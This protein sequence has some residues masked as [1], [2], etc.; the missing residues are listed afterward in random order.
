MTRSSWTFLA[1][2][3]FVLSLSGAAAQA[4]ELRATTVPYAVEVAGIRIGT[5]EITADRAEEAYRVQAEGRYRVLFWS[6]QISV[7]SDGA[8]T[9]ERPAPR[10]YW[11][12]TRS[13]RASALEI[14]FSP[15]E[16]KPTRWERTPPAP[17]EWTE[18]ALP[19]Q[20]THLQGAIDPATAIAASLLKAPQEGAPPLCQDP[21]RV[22]SGFTVFELRYET[23]E[24]I[25]EDRIDCAATYTP[26]SGH[27]EGSRSVE[28]IAKP[29]AIRLSF[30]RLDGDLWAPAAVSMPT[31]VGT[32]R[33]TKR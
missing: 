8:M 16:A 12:E 19:L 30:Q 33:I 17:A 6:G 9:E 1:A 25:G 13:R 23:V 20:E 26:L 11:L 28:R 14:E 15:E 18:N 4:V 7:A 2:S 10:R 31:T 22:F 32:L 5:F 21:V 24:R 29:S 27:R 3:G